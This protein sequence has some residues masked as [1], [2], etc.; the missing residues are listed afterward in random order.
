[1]TI[2]LN[3]DLPR[4]RKRA[5]SEAGKVAH[6]ADGATQA[7]AGMHLPQ[8]DVGGTLE[9]ARKTI[10]DVRSTLGDV[11]H[12]LAEGS[13]QV[14]KG[15]EQ[16]AVRA[17]ELGHGVRGAVGDL[18]SL[19]LVRQQPPRRDVWPGVALIGGIGAG[20]AAMFLFDPQD[21]ARRRALLRGKLGR[22]S[23]L[24]SERLSGTAKDLRDR[25]QGLIQE[26]RSA[27]E[28]RVPSQPEE[29]STPEWPVQ[30]PVGAGVGASGYGELTHQPYPPNGRDNG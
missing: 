21:G 2:S 1:M 4:L 27:I 30:E 3:L 8:V 12:S 16:V 9:S 7:L 29:E 25:S 13:G 14:T 28:T 17:S 19:R 26:T 15:A 11:R 5:Q 18:R 10:V 6:A 22:W 23:R 24:A 20:V